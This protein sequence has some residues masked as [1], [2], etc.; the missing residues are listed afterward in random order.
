[1]LEPW[2]IDD[3]CHP[4]NGLRLCVVEDN[5]AE[6]DL[7]SAML[8]TAAVDVEITRA[9]CVSDLEA[10]A[11]L[12]CD[13]ILLDLCLP[14]SRGLDTVSR[15]RSL[16]PKSPIIVMTSEE[17]HSNSLGSLELGV[18]DYIVKGTLSASGIVRA[19]YGAIKRKKLEAELEEALQ[20]AR[21][22]ARYDDLTGLL[23]RSALLDK[24]ALVQRT[25][26]P[27]D[28]LALLFVDLDGFKTVNDAHGHVAGDELLREMA[29]L[30]RDS[31]REGDVIGRLGGD[32]FVALLVGADRET[33]V[34]IARRLVLEVRHPYRCNG[35]EMEVTVSVGVAVQSAQLAVGDDLMRA[36]DHAMYSAKLRG[37]AQ[38]SVAPDDRTDT[39]RG[40]CMP[41]GSR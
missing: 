38:V 12:Q 11:P 41:A 7:L 23:S 14:D 35:G 29:T 24:L 3:S 39:R 22:R 30:L 17:D 37:G 16:D 33:A 27:I 34:Q 1:M 28:D 8:R 18:Q 20:R 31:C 6:Y 40:R 21:E 19:V 36:A 25:D 2:A 13:A 4:D 5:Q 10:S 9:A 26:S 32:E 15:V